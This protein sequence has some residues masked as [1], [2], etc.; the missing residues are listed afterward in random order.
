MYETAYGS[1]KEVRAAIAIGVAWGWITEPAA[2]LRTLDRLLGLL[3]GL[4]KG[5]V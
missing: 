4:R 3:W 5:T 2:L 1:A